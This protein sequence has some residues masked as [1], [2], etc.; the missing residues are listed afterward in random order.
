MKVLFVLLLATTF[1]SAQQTS[2]PAKS[3][4]PH[5]N[6]TRPQPAASPQ[7]RPNDMNSLLQEELPNLKS[8]LAELRA[9]LNVMGSQEISLDT[10]T[11]GAF[12]TNRQMWQVV[13]ARLAELTQRMDALE[14]S[15]GEQLP[16]AHPDQP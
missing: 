6:A 12:Q 16:K 5:P 10:R 1:A 3:A 11:G 8:D 7:V 13:I 15:Q 2:K 4:H 14:R 9:M